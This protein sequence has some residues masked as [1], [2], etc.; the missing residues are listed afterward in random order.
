MLY[1]VFFYKNLLIIAYFFV[2]LPIGKVIWQILGSPLPKDS[3]SKVPSQRRTI[4]R[5]KPRWKIIS[6]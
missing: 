1:G 2:I 6:F 5:A 4:E 3:T